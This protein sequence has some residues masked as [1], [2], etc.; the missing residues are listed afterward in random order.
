MAS[1]DLHQIFKLRPVVEFGEDMIGYVKHVEQ[2]RKYMQMK[3]EMEHI[4]RNFLVIQSKRS[5][6]KPHTQAQCEPC[7]DSRP[8]VSFDGYKSHVKNEN[9]KV[10]VIDVPLMKYDEH[11]PN[12]SL[13]YM[14]QNIPCMQCN[15]TFTSMNYINAH[16]EACHNIVCYCLECEKSFPSKKDL[17]HHVWNDNCGWKFN[18]AN[19]SQGFKCENTLNMHQPTCG[20]FKQEQHICRFQGC[21]FSCKT[22]K[23]MRDHKFKAHKGI[24]VK[25]DVCDFASFKKMNLAT[26]R[27]RNHNSKILKCRGQEGTGGCGREFKRKDSL[28]EHFKSCGLPFLK[29]WD[30]LSVTQKRRRARAQLE[31][32]ITDLDK[33]QNF[34]AS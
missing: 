22:W 33:S 26:H 32:S 12:I 31:G 15:Q 19:C 8:D 20:V 30:Q 3:E 9:P 24:N 28:K 1:S 13:K 11:D 7:S 5:K 34:I 17:Q 2:Y 10:S 18:C 6:L 25:C 16:I 27:K 4:K 23:K 14:G 29:P 21:V